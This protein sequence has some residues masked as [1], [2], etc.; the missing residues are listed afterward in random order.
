MARDLFCRSAW[1]IH[2]PLK[3]KSMVT[4]LSF[5]CT[6]FPPLNPYF[7]Y[8]YQT[9]FR[10]PS[11]YRPLRVHFQTS[12]APEY[13]FDADFPDLTI[14]AKSALLHRKIALSHRCFRQCRNSCNAL[15]ILIASFPFVCIFTD[16]R[17]PAP[18]GHFRRCSLYPF[19]VSWPFDKDIQSVAIRT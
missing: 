11:D 3:G 12:H 2:S 4:D 15:A 19:P 1:A 16:A 8:A 9:C 10:K 5:I 6:Y 7:R 13:N 14:D 18:L 17:L